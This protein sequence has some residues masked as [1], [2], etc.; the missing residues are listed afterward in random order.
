VVHAVLD[1]GRAQGW[2]ELIL[3]PVD[4]AFEHR[5]RFDAM[6]RLMTLLRRIPNLRIEADGMNGNPAGL[7]QVMPLIDIFALHDGPFYRRGQYDADAWRSFTTQ[8]AAQRGAIWFYNVDISGWRPEMGR[9]LTS[10]HPIRCGA[11]GVFTWSWLTVVPDP[12]DPQQLGRAAFMHEYPALGDEPGG[13]SPSL[14][15][16]RAGIEDHRLWRT[17][18]GRLAAGRGTP[19]LQAAV[20]QVQAMLERIDYAAWDSGPTQGR[21]TRESVSDEGVPLFEGD[22]KAPTGW[23]HEDYD[24]AREL[25]LAALAA[26]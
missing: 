6:V 8:V 2:P 23:S 26:G 13:P 11:S 5:D 9:F 21:W 16:M 24:R 20:D 22:L 18:Q 7:D 14:W 17:A 4:E 3:Q 12:Y 15:A 25:L 10:W 1:Y 19:A